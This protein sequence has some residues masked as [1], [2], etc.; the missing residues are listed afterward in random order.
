M[1]IIRIV[2][3]IANG[4]WQ[5]LLVVAVVAL[6]LAGVELPLLHAL[7]FVVSG[8][9]LAGNVGYIWRTV[10]RVQNAPPIAS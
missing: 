9:V 2:P 10:R 6:L 8:F 3:L 7:P 4:G 5:L 1:K